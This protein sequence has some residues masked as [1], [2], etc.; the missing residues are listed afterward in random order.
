MV[1]EDD[2]HFLNGLIDK[3]LDKDAC[4]ICST[5]QLASQTEDYFDEEIVWREV[6]KESV[7]GKPQ[8][9]DMAPM[10]SFHRNFDEGFWFATTLARQIVKEEYV[11]SNQVVCIDCTVQRVRRHL[12]KLIENINSGWLP[13]E[14]EIED[15]RYDNF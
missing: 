1:N 7:T 9:Y 14:N 5:G 15:P 2:K 11:I 3:C 8:D 4:Y 6:Q 12:V 13:N 10:T